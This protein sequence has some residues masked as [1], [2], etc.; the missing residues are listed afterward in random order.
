AV[1]APEIIEGDHRPAQLRTG[2]QHRVRDHRRQAYLQTLD[3]SA[4]PPN[5]AGR[6][7]GDDAASLTP[8]A[9]VLDEHAVAEVENERDRRVRDHL[10]VDEFSGSIA[11]S[12][13]A[14]S[15]QPAGA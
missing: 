8:T 3:V 12:G 9:G 13:H 11:E 1:A 4:A 5:A 10:Q 15:R 6:E 7:A 14:D 2:A